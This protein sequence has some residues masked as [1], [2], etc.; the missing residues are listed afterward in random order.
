MYVGN[1]PLGATPI[2]QWGWAIA[3]DSADL[4]RIPVGG[5]RHRSQ[6]YARADGAQS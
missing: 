4:S 1:R 5:K 3:I 2:F 6:Q